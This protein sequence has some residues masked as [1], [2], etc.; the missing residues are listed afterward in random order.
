MRYA[1][2]LL[3]RAEAEY[4]L[5]TSNAANIGDAFTVIN[6][7]RS[8]AGAIPLASAASMTIDTIRKE[9][10]K[11]LAFEN[12]TWWDLRRW[13]TADRAADLGRCP[14]YAEEGG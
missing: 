2:V 10:R 13:R 6:E 3:N 14:R 5:G 11:E 12:K 1:E 7:I 9:R 8:R 4:E